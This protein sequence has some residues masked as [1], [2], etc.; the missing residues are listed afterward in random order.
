VGLALARGPLLGIGFALASQGV[1]GIG[2]PDLAVPGW[3]AF[4]GGA[5]GLLM[6]CAVRMLFPPGSQQLQGAHVPADWL[7]RSGG[8]DG[9]PQ[10]GVAFWSPRIAALLSLEMCLLL[11]AV[12]NVGTR[13]TL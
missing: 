1:F 2:R 7:K 6:S 13:L 12:R 10:S 3:I 8:S 5:T 11:I 4:Y 9:N